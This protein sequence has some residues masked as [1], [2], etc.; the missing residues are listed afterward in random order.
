[1]QRE[2]IQKLQLQS[3]EQRQ[4]H[5]EFHGMIQK[6][7]EKL[8]SSQKSVEDGNKQLNDKIE[9]KY[10]EFADGH[11]FDQVLKSL[12]FSSMTLREETI[13]KAYE[14]TFD[15]IFRAEE[16]TLRPGH[17]FV[18]WLREGSGVYWIYGKAGSGKSTLMRFIADKPDLGQHLALWKTGSDLIVAKHFF[19]AMGDEKQHDILGLLRSLLVQLLQACPAFVEALQLSPRHEIPVWSEERLFAGNFSPLFFFCSLTNVTRT[20]VPLRSNLTRTQALKRLPS[21]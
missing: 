20:R 14:N 7:M 16:H 3:I 18:K 4:S 2:T 9:Q 12:S 15:W 8:E 6:L 1:M 10:H 19:W 13:E 17:D 21:Q 5:Q 11:W